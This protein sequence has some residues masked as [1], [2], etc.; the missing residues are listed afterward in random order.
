LQI[1]LQNVSARSSNPP[2]NIQTKKIIEKVAISLIKPKT[3]NK[4]V[5]EWND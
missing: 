3:V 4:K 5:S 1:S 2:S